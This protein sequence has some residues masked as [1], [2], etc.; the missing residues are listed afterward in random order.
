MPLRSRIRSQLPIHMLL[1]GKKKR[2]MVVTPVWWRSVKRWP[3]LRKNKWYFWYFWDR[4]SVKAPE[5]TR[6][7]VHGMIRSLITKPTVQATSTTHVK[8][9]CNNGERRITSHYCNTGSCIGSNAVPYQHMHC[10]REG[11][12]KESG[13]KRKVSARHFH[14]AQ[15]DKHN[16]SKYTPATTLGGSRQY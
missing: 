3:C 4:T 13:S 8:T 16:S 10:G 12:R 6:R 5:N 1:R 2:E 11:L 9:Q 15:K 7:G 14:R